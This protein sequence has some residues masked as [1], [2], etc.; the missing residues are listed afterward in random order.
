MSTTLRT[1]SPQEVVATWGGFISLANFA[2]GTAIE[3]ERNTDNS[4]QLV[5]M[6][7]DVGLTYNADKTGQV[8]MTFMQTA[9]TNRYLS[10]IQ[11]LQDDTGEL[12]RAD[13]VISDPSGSSLCFARNCHIV[14]ASTIS[15]GDDQNSREW[16][17]F[18]EQVEYTAAPIGF[19]SS[20]ASTTR[21]ESAASN[22]QGVSAALNNLLS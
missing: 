8:T 11:K 4:S 20:T 13:I 2:E 3:I 21:I 14:T 17:W 7:G 16:V 15:L 9:E 5:G 10:Q 22:L 19:T 6:Q 18:A 12:I 1:Y